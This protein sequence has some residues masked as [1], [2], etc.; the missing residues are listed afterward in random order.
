MRKHHDIPLQFMIT[1]FSV[2]TKPFTYS[3]EDQIQFAKY[4]GFDGVDYIASVKDLFLRPNDILHLEK[5]YKIKVK[6]L[7]IP[8]PLVIYTPNFLLNKINN[9]LNYFPENLIFNFHLSGFV[10]PLGKNLHGL[11]SLKKIMEKT[12]IKISCES[13]PDE[14]GIFKYYPKVTYDPD[15]FARF[16]INHN[17]PIN[18]DTCHISAWNYDIVEFFRKYHAHINLIHLSDMTSDRQHLPLGKGNLPIIKFLKELK[19]ASYKGIVVFE[20]SR[21]ANAPKEQVKKEVKN[22]LDIF[23][24]VAFF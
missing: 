22:S 4:A 9:L 6:G 24:K 5:K 7:H 12:K 3:I 10:N 18:I 13:N 16:C 8:L 20:I 17:L 23:R 15:M 1:L 2:F 14:Y 21:F 11:E 19:R